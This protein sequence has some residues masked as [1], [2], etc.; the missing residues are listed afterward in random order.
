MKNPLNIEVGYF[1]YSK[2][3]IWLKNKLRLTWQWIANQSLMI[4]HWFKNLCFIYLTTRSQPRVF[5]GYGHWWFAQRYADKRAKISKI[6]KVGGGKRH[7]VLPCDDYAL[8]VV[9]HIEINFYKKTGLFNK[10]LNI[11]SILKHAYYITK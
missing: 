7:Y 1:K 11:N 5:R 8:I 4:W 3:W 10:S 6:N 9:N 2:F